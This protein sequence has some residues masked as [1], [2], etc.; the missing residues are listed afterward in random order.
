MRGVEAHFGSLVT[1]FDRKQSEGPSSR[2]IGSAA[3][4]PAS[5]IASARPPKRG[6]GLLTPSR[7]RPSAR[8]GTPPA[9]YRDGIRG[10]SRGGYP[11]RGRGAFRA[12]RRPGPA[13][14]AR[15]GYHGDSLPRRREYPAP[16]YDSRDTRDIQYSRERRPV[17][18]SER[19]ST[20]LSSST[21]ST[22][23]GYDGF[24]S[25]PSNR[26]DYAL[27]PRQSYGSSSAGLDRRRF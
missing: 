17:Y 4:R 16:G 14:G 25:T 10:S 2:H 3:K 24:S 15:G 23:R 6:R 21:Y 18:S 19:P 9:S 8:S 20:Y 12:T 7:G 11:P 1:R 26:H 13:R 27:Q 22:P 5:T